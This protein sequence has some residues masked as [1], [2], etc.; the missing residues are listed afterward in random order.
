[1][2]AVNVSLGVAA[3]LPAKAWIV[4]VRSRQRTLPREDER[5]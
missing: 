4:V 5:P 1:M 3:M 2:P